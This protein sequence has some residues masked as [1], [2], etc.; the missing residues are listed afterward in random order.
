M[1]QTALSHTL[2]PPV[3][4]E[5]GGMLRSVAAPVP[6]IAERERERAKKIERGSES[7]TDGERGRG[8][9]S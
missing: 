2:C 7:E 4:A 1:L 5:T 3:F 8:R 9:G 6:D